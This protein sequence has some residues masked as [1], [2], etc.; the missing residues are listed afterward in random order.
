MFLKL[1]SGFVDAGKTSTLGRLQ[2]AL[3]ANYSKVTGPLDEYNDTVD[4]F[5][6]MF[7]YGLLNLVIYC[8]G[9]I[10]FRRSFYVVFFHANYSPF[11]G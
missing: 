8:G 1:F 3:L 10:H 11:T 6:S 7:L 9:H 5:F 2:E 4:V